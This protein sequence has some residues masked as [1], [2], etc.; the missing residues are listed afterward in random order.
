MDAMNVGANDASGRIVGLI[1]EMFVREG[2]NWFESGVPTKQGGPGGA[3]RW[4]GACT[5]S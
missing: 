4:A 3:R 2:S 5:R 1:H